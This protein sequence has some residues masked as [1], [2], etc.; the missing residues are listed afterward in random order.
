MN[1]LLP[2]LF[3][4]EQNIKKSNKSVDFNGN[5]FGGYT[6]IYYNKVNINDYS[7]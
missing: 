1:G 7:K 6:E 4:I 3:L 2:D 5:I